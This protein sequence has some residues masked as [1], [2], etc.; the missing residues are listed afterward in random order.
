[1]SRPFVKCEEV[2]GAITIG[3]LRKYLDLFPDDGE[4]WVEW[5]KGVSS[6]VKSLWPL[7]VSQESCDLLLDLEKDE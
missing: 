7:N 3:Q 2:G 4:V 5:N 1:M 6:A